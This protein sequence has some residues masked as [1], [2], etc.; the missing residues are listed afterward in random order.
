MNSLR[1]LEFFDDSGRPV[2]G[3]VSVRH[4]GEAKSPH[5]QAVLRQVEEHQ[6]EPIDF[7][8]F[9]RFEESN[10]RQVRSSQVLAYVVDNSSLKHSK[11]ELADLHHK[12]WLQGAAPLIYVAWPTCVDILSCARQPDFWSQD[13]GRPEY[14][15]AEKVN[16]DVQGHVDGIFEYAADISDAMRKR[17]RLSANRLMDGTFWEEHDNQKLAKDD[18]AAHNLLIKA[19]VDA[20]ET[21][22]GTNNPVRRRLLLLMVLITYLEDRGVFPPEYFGYYRAGVRSFRE[23]L[24]NG[25]VD[26]VARLLRYLEKKKFN[27]DVFALSHEGESL[28]DSDLKVFAILV[29]GKTLG[30]Q[31]HF[32]ELFDFRHIP[33]EVISSLY[34]HFVTTDNA[35]YTPPV[36]ASLLLDHVMP[37]EQMTGN[38]RV[39]DPSCGSGIFL[40]G[41]FKRLVTHWRSRNSWRRPS[42]ETLKSILLNSIYGVELEQQSV[43]LTAF[44][45]ALALCDSL[46]PPVIW[47]D[48]TFDKL[49]GRNLRTGNFFKADTFASKGG[50]RWPSKFDIVVGNPPFESKLTTEETSTEDNESR[51]AIKIPDRQAAYLFL[52]RGLKLLSKCG[53]ICLLQ[54]ANLLYGTST[55]KFRRYVM[56]L[57]KVETVLDFVSIR[58]LFDAADTKAVA[59]HAVNQ[60][61]NKDPL[62]HLTFRRTYAA[63]QRVAFEIDHYDFHLVSRQD[64]ATSPFVWKAN[65]LGG[66]RLHEM[67]QRL[68]RLQTLKEF[69]ELK[70][71][72]YGEGFNYGNRNQDATFLVGMKFLPTAALSESGVDESQLFEN[73]ESRFESP[74][75]PELFAPPVVLIKEH[76]SL[77]AA[78][79]DRCSLGFSHSI[80]G[81]HAPPADGRELKE[82]FRIFQSRKRLYQFTCLLNGGRA[83]VAKATSILKHDIDR[84]PVP[85]NPADIDLS[86]WEDI[87]KDEALDL[88]SEFVRLGQESL[89]LKVAASEKDVGE[90]AK[91]YVRMLG[92]IFSNLKHADAVRLNG[93][94]AQPFYFGQRPEVKWLRRDTETALH[95]LIYDGNGQALRVVRIIRYYENNVILFVK[96]DR[97]R[98]W[99]RSTAIRDADDTLSELREQGW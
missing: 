34:Q 74:R 41:A 45:L 17:K 54:P 27:G 79:W 64:A 67:S 59:W 72:Q 78:Y 85:D 29:E 77:P 90:Y 63:D 87:L 69:V 60:L 62:I 7:V 21:I 3:L 39:L 92:S 35:I 6:L 38:E 81:I 56:G 12:L 16:L 47:R 99:I 24:K 2:D 94:I 23:L 40:V 68:G 22:D 19:I 20:D 48:L 86:Y 37:Y 1:E 76:S 13:N 42:V 46:D 57:A 32:W 18:V 31:K 89:V 51:N 95:R 71:W 30:N 82:F 75:R 44:S 73:R 52:E 14:S 36:L 33:V 91:L 9:R 83:L 84:L 25:T 15:E 26:E 70:K 66:G 97:L 50:H 80:V 10:G 65:L 53:A 96:P 8:F 58:G 88:M 43:D 49:C 98:Y 93:L 55:S 11:A 5:E 4:A 61:D 28:A